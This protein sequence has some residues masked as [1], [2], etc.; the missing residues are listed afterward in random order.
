MNVKKIIRITWLSLST[1]R[2]MPHYIIMKLHSSC[3]V[4]ELDMKRWREQYGA[5]LSVAV[6]GDSTWE[7]FLLLMQLMTYFPEFRSLFYF[8][9]GWAGKVMSSL[10][11]PMPILSLSR[12]DEGVGPGFLIMHG[13][14]TGVAAR[15]I[16]SNFTVFQL[17]S[18][19]YMNENDKP[20]IGDNVTVFAGAKILGKVNIGNNCLV[21]ANAVVLKD[22]PDN[23]TVVGVPA[24]IVRRN[25]VKV[26]ESL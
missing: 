17:V 2:L 15:K 11:R 22:V 24:Y 14:A 4:I 1:V 5:H 18:I 9:T 25:G 10:C 13:R 3:A 20:T 6:N 21:G 23:C 26:K 16:G 8:R 7:M 19:G 12:V